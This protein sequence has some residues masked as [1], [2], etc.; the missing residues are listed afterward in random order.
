MLA[1][2]PLPRQRN[3]CGPT[4]ELG[5]CSNGHHDMS[6]ESLATPDLAEALSETGLY[7]EIASEPFEDAD[8]RAWRN[9]AGTMMDIT[10][11]LEAGTGTRQVPDEYGP[12]WSGPGREL[13]SAARQQMWGDPDDPDDRGGFAFS[14]VGVF[15]VVDSASADGGAE[16]VT[17]SSA[18]LFDL[19]PD[20]QYAAAADAHGRGERADGHAGP[21]GPMT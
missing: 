7:R 21:L 10:Q 9:Q 1:V 4:D 14:T 11:H 20:H 17:V 16:I 6:C 13:V 3:N 19:D 2:L 8:A 15:V 18:G 12:G 5:Y